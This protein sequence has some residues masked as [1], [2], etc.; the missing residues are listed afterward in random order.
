MSD[1][2]THD[3]YGLGRVVEVERNAVLVDFGERTVR[4]SAPYAKLFLL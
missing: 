1:R 2:V 3:K 4:I